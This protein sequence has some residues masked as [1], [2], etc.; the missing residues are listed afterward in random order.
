MDHGWPPERLRAEFDTL[1]ALEASGFVEMSGGIV[2]VR[3]DARQWLEAICGVFD[4]D[5][6]G[7]EAPPHQT[8]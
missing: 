1:S 8:A 2:R 5:R 6:G 4:A 7:G 3:P